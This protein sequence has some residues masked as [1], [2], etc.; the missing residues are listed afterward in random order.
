MKENNFQPKKYEFK[1]GVVLDIN[2]QKIILTINNDK[3]TLNAENID[4]F[5]QQEH[6]EPTMSRGTLLFWIIGISFGMVA[7]SEIYLGGWSFFSWSLTFILIAINIVIFLIFMI[8][9]LLELGIFRRIVHHYFSN[10]GILFTIGNNSGNNLDI[11]VYKEEHGKVLDL[12]KTIEELRIFKKEMRQIN[13]VASTRIS[14][15]DELKKLG[16]LLESNIITK[17]EFETK[18][19][20]LLK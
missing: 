11:I 10:E 6:I 4:N 13:N 14:N 17:E 18:K 1:N 9:E 12:E 5:G 8:D 20:E 15:L 2:E 19:S 7:L 16:E 3:K